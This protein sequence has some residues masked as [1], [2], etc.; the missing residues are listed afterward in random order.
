VR[1]CLVFFPL[2]WTSYCRKNKLFF[3]K[4]RHV[5]LL[6]YRYL[7][8]DGDSHYEIEIVQISTVQI[9]TEGFTPGGKFFIEYK[10]IRKKIREVVIIVPA[11][12]CIS[13]LLVAW[14]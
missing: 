7:V 1:D 14:V 8:L 2:I 11:R 3:L 4:K 10:L 12:Q 9:L 13:R 6:L 5:F